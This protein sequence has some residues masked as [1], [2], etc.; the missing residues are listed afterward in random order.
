MANGN[1]EGWLQ[2]AQWVIQ[3]TVEK[4]GAAT[5]KSLPA[6]RNTS[7]VKV[8]DVLHGPAQFNDHRGRRVT[9]YSER[10]QGLRAGQRAVFFTRSWLYGESLAVVEVGRL[11]GAT[12][13]MR[14]EIAAA[15]QRIADRR[16]GERIGL[17][18][19]VV[20]GKVA[21]VKAASQTGRRIET[22]HAPDWWEAQVEVQS[23]EKGSTR[24]KSIAVLY[25]NSM[26]EMWIDSPKFHAGQEGVWI[27]QRNQQEKG[28]P[29]LRVP[30][31]TALDPLDFHAKDQLD[32]IRRLIRSR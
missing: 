4:T 30:G 28:W 22:E 3:A 21:D 29:V 8:D 9:L 18:R 26:D 2:Q 32:R 20:V 11:G 31:L 16:L 19:L 25:P 10:P 12:D 7:I 23:V 13:T 17:A 24:E 15:D 5:L 6:S 27:L 14:K 1:I